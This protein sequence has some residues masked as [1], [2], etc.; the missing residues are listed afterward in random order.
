MKFSTIAVASALFAG[1]AAAFSVQPSTAVPKT[2]LY[3][4]S[5]DNEGMLAR[6]QVLSTLAGAAAS[7][8]ASAAFAASNPADQIRDNAKGIERG[9][10]GRGVTDP[11]TSSKMGE[12]LGKNMGDRIG[13]GNALENVKSDAK[14]VASNLNPMSGNNPM[15]NMGNPMNNMGGMGGMGGMGNPAQAIKD[16]AKGIENKTGASNKLTSKV[17]SDVNTVKGQGGMMNNMNPFSGNNNPMNNMGMGGMGNPADKIKDNAK[18]IERNT[19]ASNR[20]TSKVNS[21]VNTVK[22]QGGGFFRNPFAGN[23]PTNDMPNPR[24][25]ANKVKNDVKS[26]ADNANPFKSM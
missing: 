21:D 3:A 9:L 1:S 5:N 26:V 10:D 11:G 24:Q 22:G 14:S 4:S 16:N 7:L 6:R 25:A 23:N 15:N 18:G 17:G 2:A 19:G 13:A 12:N 20:L 8:G